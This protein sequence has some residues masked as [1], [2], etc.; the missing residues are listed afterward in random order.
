[1]LIN[2]AKIYL[3]EIYRE[4]SAK[5]NLEDEFTESMTA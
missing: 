1:M 4:V 5:A 3:T 2:E